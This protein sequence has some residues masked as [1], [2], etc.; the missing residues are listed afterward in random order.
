MEEFERSK[1]AFHLGPRDFNRSKTSL[2][3]NYE[4]QVQVI[5]HQTGELEEIRQKLGLSARKMCQLLLVDPSTWTRWTRPGGSPPPHVWRSIQWFLALQEKV[6]G[7]TAGYFLSRPEVRV[8]EKPDP[9]PHEEFVNF[10]KNFERKYK[11]LVKLSVMGWIAFLIAVLLPRLGFAQT[12]KQI[13]P[14]DMQGFHW[15]ITVPPTGSI[16]ANSKAVGRDMNWILRNPI[17]VQKLKDRG[18]KI[19]C[20]FNM[21]RLQ[22]NPWKSPENRK[23]AY[24]GVY[25]HYSSIKQQDTCE[26]IGDKWG[27][28]WISWKPAHQAKALSAYQGIINEASLACDG[29]EYD[30]LDVAENIVDS[31]GKKTYACGNE[32]DQRNVIKKVCDMTHKAGMSCFLKN[33]FD[34][35]KLHGQQFDGLIGEQCFFYQGNAEAASAGFK[36]KPIACIE[37]KNTDVEGEGAYDL[38]KY[39]ADCRRAKTLGLTNFWVETSQGKN[40]HPVPG[41]VCENIPSRSAGGAGLG[42]SG[43]RR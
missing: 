3:M 27:E 41:K 34:D 25:R 15:S 18:I 23:E 6:P 10:K 32:Q 28:P 14:Q 19:L 36:G 8:I 30:N 9:N 40:G 26:E 2:R 11:R 35:A 33:S 31:Q 37:Y 42:G 39:E 7:L 1:P 20:Y 12:Y 22:A 24:D 38:S 43:A 13:T 21:G 29:L 4:A 16:P 5:K 17:E